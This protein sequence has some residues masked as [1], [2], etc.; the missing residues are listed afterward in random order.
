MH[1]I[2]ICNFAYLQSVKYNVDK[3]IFKISYDIIYD[4]LH[5]IF[6]R[7]IFSI[8]LTQIGF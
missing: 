1:I 3:T 6:I 2:S 7:Q 4:N 5:I 8:F